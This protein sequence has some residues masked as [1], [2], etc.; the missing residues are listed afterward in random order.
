MN[1][2]GTIQIYGPQ[3]VDINP[4]G[5][6]VP[7]IKA[8]TPS[9]DEEE[10]LDEFGAPI[11]EFDI[12]G[13]PEAFRGIASAPEG[14]ADASA[15]NA[16]GSI[17]ERILPEGAPIVTLGK[18][19]GGVATAIVGK[20]TG[21]EA[22]YNTAVEGLRESQKENVD[23]LILLGT[24]GR[25]SGGPRNVHLAG[26]VH[27]KTGIPFNKAGYPD[28]SSVATK[29]VTIKRTGTRRGDAAAANKAAGF[30]KTPNGYTWHHHEDGTTM[31]LV[32]RDIHANTGHTG[33]FS[34]NP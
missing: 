26:S 9:E 8:A 15:A 28:F 21:D 13:E 29:T 18:A 23:V 31:Q 17:I 19:L 33:G 34:L 30:E 25:G 6:K 7:K 1:A 4:D 16:P 3:R 27:P 20:A 10:E 11:E 32:P 22:L 24:A 2:D 14:I 5:V 12:M